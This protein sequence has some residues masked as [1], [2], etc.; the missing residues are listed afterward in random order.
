MND[1][2]GSLFAF[3]KCQNPSK[4]NQKKNFGKKH[5]KTKLHR[6]DKASLELTLRVN[7]FSNI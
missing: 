1:L 7:K 2:F 5:L 4:N 6:K 3:S